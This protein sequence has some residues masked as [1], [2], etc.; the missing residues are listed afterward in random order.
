[1]KPEIIYFPWGF[2]GFQH[3][4]NFY[5]RKEA[6]IEP[7]FFLEQYGG[8]IRFIACD[9]FFFFPEYQPS[10]GRN[11]LTLLEVA[12]GAILFL[13]T[14]VNPRKAPP[15]LNLKAPILIDWNQKKGKQIIISN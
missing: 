7:Y 10:I 2:P 14:L 1:M 15:L 5:F 3:I 9:P 13:I 6:K 4:N 11:D 12:E 8:G